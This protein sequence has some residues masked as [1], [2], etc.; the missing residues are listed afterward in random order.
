MAVLHRFYCILQSF[1]VSLKDD[2]MP[3]LEEIFEIRLVAVRS[4]DNETGSTDVSGASIDPD[5]S[6]SRVVMPENNYPYGL[7]QFSESDTPPL[8]ND[9]YIPP[10]TLSPTVS[11][12]AEFNFFL[13]SCKF[14][15]L[16]VTFAN[17]LDPDQ[18]RQNVGPDLDP[19]RFT[20][21]KNFLKK[22][23]FVCLILFFMSHQ[24]SFS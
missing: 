15:H 10:A 16:L 4:D 5:N 2:N 6:K 3:E 22:F 9:P 11:H 12:F 8:P 13:A 7:L 23:L 19:N 21:S 17:S 20:V 14:S 1:S 18:A 24:Q